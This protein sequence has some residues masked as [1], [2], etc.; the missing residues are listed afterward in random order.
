MIHAY[1]S[2]R[3]WRERCHTASRS[4]SNAF[5]PS[6]ILD[7]WAGLP[8]ESI[9]R[10]RTPLALSTNTD[11]HAIWNYQIFGLRPYLPANKPRRW[12]RLSLRQWWWRTRMISWDLSAMR[13][14]KR[15]IL[16][17][18]ENLCR[19][20]PAIGDTV[21][22]RHFEL[23]RFPRPHIR[24]HWKQYLATCHPVRR[25]SNSTRYFSSLSTIAFLSIFDW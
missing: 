22:Y 4:V 24:V 6:H 5:L 11:H 8:V 7:E 21:L 23:T 20:P 3:I 9:R 18:I 19:S 15:N 14:F 10:A 16:W 12:I 1:Y 2:V 17:V 25:K 13:P